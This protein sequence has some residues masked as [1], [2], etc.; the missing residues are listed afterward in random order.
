MKRCEH[1]NWA[2][3]KDETHCPI[4]KNKVEEESNDDIEIS[5]P[6]MCSPSNIIFYIVYN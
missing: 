6:D 5:H 3:D 1:C 4:C 2:L